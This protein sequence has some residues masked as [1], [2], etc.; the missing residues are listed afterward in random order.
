MQFVYKGHVD[1][2]QMYSGGDMPVLSNFHE[3]AIR[4][5]FLMEQVTTVLHI[6][7]ASVIIIYYAYGSGPSFV[8]NF[9]S[10]AS[11]S[12]CMSVK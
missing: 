6:N 3:N 1:I 5:G 12:F 7:S 10:P 2:V 8:P 4:R 11:S 9:H